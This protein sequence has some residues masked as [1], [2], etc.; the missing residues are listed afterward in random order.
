MNLPATVEIFNK[1]T[2]IEQRHHVYTSLLSL[3]TNEKLKYIISGF[4]NGEFQI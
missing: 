4:I 2:S 3:D 1:F